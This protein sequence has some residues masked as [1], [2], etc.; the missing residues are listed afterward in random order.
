MQFFPECFLDRISLCRVP[1]RDE[2][3][4]LSQFSSWSPG[5]QN[6]SYNLLSLAQFSFA[7]SLPCT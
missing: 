1:S 6:Q 4:D 5:V 2:T 3:P 7:E